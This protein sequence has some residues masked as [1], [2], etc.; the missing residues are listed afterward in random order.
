M[1]F[2]E[3]LRRVLGGEPGT[4]ADSADSAAPRAQPHEPR[5]P[6]LY[7]RVK[8]EKKMKRILDDLPASE[9][10]WEGLLSEARALQFDPEW[11]MR[12]QVQEF[13]LMLHRAVADRHVTE[14]EHRKLEQA[15]YLIGISEAEAE[16]ALHSAIAEAE[17]F[18]G[19]PVEED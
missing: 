16:A 7:D 6:G 15:R 10:E 18:F 2:F 12:S 17:K 9:G 14:A 8:W 5:A 1:G 11:V 3:T 13:V 4:S 19:K